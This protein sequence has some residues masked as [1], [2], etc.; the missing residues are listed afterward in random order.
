[1]SWLFPARLAG[2]LLLWAML[3]PGVADAKGS[4]RGHSSSHSSSSTHHGSRAVPGVKCDSHGHI[5]R[6]SAAKYGFKNS[7]PCPSTGRSSG[8]CPGYVIDHVTPLTP[9]G[10]DSP[11]N[12]QWQTAEAEK[13]G[14]KTE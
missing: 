13:I 7:H 9:D 11:S 12:M 5:A 1:M 6:S 2:V 8:L 14:D 3:L 10:A 4:S